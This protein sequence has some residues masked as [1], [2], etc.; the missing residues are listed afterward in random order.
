MKVKYH[1][2]SLTIVKTLVIGT[3]QQPDG[4][5]SLDKYVYKNHQIKSSSV[6]IFAPSYPMDSLD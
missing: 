3:F 6:Y 4:E 1:R 2:L 5:I